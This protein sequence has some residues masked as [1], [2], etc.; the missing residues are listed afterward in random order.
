[1]PKCELNLGLAVFFKK[2]LG[3][4]EF[5]LLTIKKYFPKFDFNEVERFIDCY[6]RPQILELFEKRLGNDFSFIRESIIL[7]K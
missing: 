4:P 3:R 1:M 2:V 7:R 5:N 6:E